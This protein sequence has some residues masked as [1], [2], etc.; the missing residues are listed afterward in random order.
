[1]L[2]AVGVLHQPGGNERSWLRCGAFRRYYGLYLG[3]SRLRLVWKTVLGNE[4]PPG[5][6]LF[7]PRR[8]SASS[9]HIEP[10]A[11]GEGKCLLHTF[12]QTQYTSIT[13]YLKSLN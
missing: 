7:R 1:M 12:P 5:R 4:K 9:G 8:S 13:L 2:V 3:P 6:L 10:D 11:Q